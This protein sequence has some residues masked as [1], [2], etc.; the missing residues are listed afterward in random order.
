[1]RRLSL[2]VLLAATF[3]CS[4]YPALYDGDPAPVALLEPAPER[5]R[6]ERVVVISIETT[7][8]ATMKC[9]A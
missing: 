3:S 6:A 5:A 8:T 7:N 1:M 4:S 9:A 2:L